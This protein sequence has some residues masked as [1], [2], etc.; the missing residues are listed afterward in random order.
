MAIW[1]AGRKDT[2]KR[3]IGRN[4]RYWRETRGMTLQD[5]VNLCGSSR[6][7]WSLVESGRHEMS[8]SRGLAVANALNVSPW[9]LVETPIKKHA[10]VSPG[11][12]AT[13]GK[14]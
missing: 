13:P 6:G 7:Y 12:D 5:I 2:L 4:V 1:S 11:R 8:F 10:P 3:T 9:L 14:E